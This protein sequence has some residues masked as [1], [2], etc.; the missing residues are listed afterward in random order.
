MTTKEY[1]EQYREDVP[2]WLRKFQPGKSRPLADFLKSR[3]VYYPGA[4]I[5]GYPVEVFGAS[6]SAHCFVYAD[7][8]L[9]KERL[10]EELHT[11]GFWGYDVLDEVSFSESEVMRAVHWLKHFLTDEE[12]R[13]AA[14]GMA[15][16]RLCTHPDPYALLAVLER[17]PGF[18][19]GHGPE[20]FA[21]LFLG[22]DGIATYEA[23]FAN[24]N[25]PQFFGFLLQDHGF[26]G[27]YDC[28]GR[29]GL[30]EKIMVRSKVY[31]HFVLTE[32]DNPYDGYERVGWAVPPS[33]K[34]R[35]LFYR[36][37]MGCL[38]PK[39]EAEDRPKMS[40]SEFFDIHLDHTY[41]VEFSKKVPIAEE[42]GAKWL[43]DT[44]C[45]LSYPDPRVAIGESM[46]SFL[47][48]PGLRM[49]GLDSFRTYDYVLVDYRG[50]TIS[51]STDP[52]PFEGGTVPLRRGMHDC[53]FVDVMIDGQVKSCYLDTGAAISYLKGMDMAKWPSAG[54]KEECDIQGNRWS[55]DTVVVP[56]CFQGNPFDVV[57]GDEKTN[58]MFQMTVDK[59]GV[60]GYDFFNA[61]TVLL[62]LREMRLS[63]KPAGK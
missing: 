7:Y 53:L 17:K 9:S 15:D 18:G 45:P 4:E 2:E 56:A 35:Y 37:D 28:F 33:N 23:V 44:G 16:M 39:D 14:R 60:I 3:I 40:V 47:G 27:N 63:F 11:H 26:G 54:V 51:C 48:V 12:R 43:V 49:M 34:R 36:A 10:L 62:D 8:M 32:Y 59:D 31:P 29:G 24:G 21:I 55:T 5:D 20:R 61:F 50:K 19:D 13:E 41:A 52:I 22:A 42:D 38:P 57:F 30:L 1:L 6:H 58:A 46:A 25:A